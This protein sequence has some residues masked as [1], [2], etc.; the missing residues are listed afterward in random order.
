MRK[1][2]I[3]LSAVG[4]AVSTMGVAD[5]ALA[6]KAPKKTKLG[7][8]MKKEKWDASVGKCAPVK[9]AAKKAAKK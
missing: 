9:K 3:A 1:F 8:V 2:F 5:T 4:F 7:C 6:A